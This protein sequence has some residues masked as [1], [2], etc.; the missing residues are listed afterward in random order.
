MSSQHNSHACKDSSCLY[1]VTDDKSNS[2]NYQTNYLID[3]AD[4]ILLL[5]VT[6]FK[7][8]KLCREFN[9][10]TATAPDAYSIRKSRFFFL[11]FKTTIP[12]NVHLS[13]S[14]T[15]LASN[16]NTTHLQPDT[17]SLNSP[18]NPPIPY[19]FR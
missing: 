17:L 3:T 14:S 8:S 13:S 2:I 9:C 12:K 18:S 10:T 7:S 16:T 11:Y 19:S 6:I 4:P 5:A 1:D 15:N